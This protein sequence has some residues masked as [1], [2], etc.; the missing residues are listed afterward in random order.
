MSQ[1]NLTD[2][3]K[4]LLKSLINAIEESNLD[5]KFLVIHSLKEI[6]LLSPGKQKGYNPP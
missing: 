5:E 2:I 1:Y 6:S 4:E 3:Q